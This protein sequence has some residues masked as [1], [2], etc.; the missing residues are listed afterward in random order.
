M[1]AA[2]L[3]DSL[4]DNV[5][6]IFRSGS[7][8]QAEKLAVV[9]VYLA[10]VTATVFWAFSGGSEDNA[11]GATYGAETLEQINK[12]MHFINNTSDDTWT[13]VVIVVNNVYQ[14][15]LE[16]MEPRK[17]LTLRPDRLKYFY[18]IPRP[19]GRAGWEELTE[20]DKPGP[21]APEDLRPELIQIRAREGKLDIDVARD[22]A[23]PTDQ[24]KAASAGGEGDG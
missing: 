22:A 23:A 10:L 9:G 1:A 24:Q 16:K 20:A 8:H 12:E 3:V 11:L 6:G 5:A 17:R 18:Y 4:R 14:Q 13:R 19:W 15:R 21:H 7:R 2:D